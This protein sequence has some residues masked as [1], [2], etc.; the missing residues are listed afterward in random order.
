MLRRLFTA[1]SALSL[2]LCLGV[3]ATWV[4]SYLNDLDALVGGARLSAE[5]GRW[6]CKRLYAYG[7]PILEEDWENPASLSPTTM[8]RLPYSESRLLGFSLA[9]GQ[10][11]RGDG[12]HQRHPRPASFWTV[13]GPLWPLALLTAVPSAYFLRT[14][15]R[16]RVRRRRARAGLC[17]SCGYDLRAT[18]GRCPECGTEASG[19][20]AS[21]TGGVEG[22]G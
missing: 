5:K 14:V 9:T 15:R 3:T 4:W 16:W 8:R 6:E 11:R 18:P 22:G 13:A 1:L 10:E 21:S 17:P 7:P 2:V 20:S 12:G 19:G